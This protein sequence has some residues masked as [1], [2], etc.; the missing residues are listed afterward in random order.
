MEHSTVKDCKL[1]CQSLKYERGDGKVQLCR[2]T[3]GQCESAQLL[4]VIPGLLFFHLN[5]RQ[6][7]KSQGQAMGKNSGILYRRRHLPETKMA[8]IHP[9]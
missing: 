5:I 8:H 6:S 4:W 7:V 1:W 2:T 3:H 9:A